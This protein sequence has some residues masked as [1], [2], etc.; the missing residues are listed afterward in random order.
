MVIVIHQATHTENAL[1][2]NEK[3][4]KEGKAVFFHSRNTLSVNPFMYDEKHRLKNLLDIEKANTR[5]KNKCLHISF[6]PSVDDYRKLGDTTIR[7]EI[8]RMMEHMGYA[9]Q[10]YFVYKHQD[11]ERVHFHVVSTRID[12]ETGRK[13]KDNYEKQKMQKFVQELEQKYDLSNQQAKEP[14]N[15]KF[16]PRSRNI[17]QNLENLF[18]HLNQMQ[19]ITSKDMYNEVLK[20]FNVE[21]KKSG[22]GHIVLVTDGEGIPIRYPIRLSKFKERP[23][24][25]VSAKVEKTMEISKQV[26]DKFQLAQWAKDL[27]R[28]VEKNRPKEAV[29]KQKIKKKK[30]KQK[31]I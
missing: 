27:N 5:V 2:Y 22:R 9:N 12:R 7:H 31:R 10:P 30:N 21:I 18:V 15:F 8:D 23:R 3:K 13:I 25:Y 19:E 24:F 4:V 28:L 14:S 11:L 6:N 17:K 1:R 16:S 26:I 20:L 29:L